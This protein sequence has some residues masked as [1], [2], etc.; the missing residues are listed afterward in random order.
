METEE[1]LGQRPL[2]RY[3]HPE[4]DI[5]STVVFLAGAGSLGQTLM[6]DGRGGFFR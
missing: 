1:M 4:H 2:P 5:G 3:G 6:V